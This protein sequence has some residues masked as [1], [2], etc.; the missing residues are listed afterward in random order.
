MRSIRSHGKLFGT[1]ATVAGATVMTLMKGPVLELFW[2]DGRINH[3]AAAKNGTDLHDS[4]KGGL[5]IVVGCF[6]YACFVI[7]QV[8]KG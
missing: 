2:T 7:L 3:E 5:M 1:L 6:S 8:S 4:I